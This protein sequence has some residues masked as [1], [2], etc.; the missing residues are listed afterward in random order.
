MRIAYINDYD[1][2]P[3]ILKLISHAMIKCYLD[4]YTYIIYKLQNIDREV[5]MMEYELKNEEI[6]IMREIDQL[7]C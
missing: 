7:I 5:N 6:P 1:C 2:Y 3:N 4:S